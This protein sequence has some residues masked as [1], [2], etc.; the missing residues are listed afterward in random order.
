MV[1][2]ASISRA[3]TS[4][5]GYMN[6]ANVSKLRVATW[7]WAA[8]IA[9]ALVG[10]SHVTRADD[11]M[12][13][14]GPLRITIECQD[15]G[16]TKACPAFLR[17][18][19]DETGL[20]LASP[21]AEAQVVLYVTQAEIA[22]TDRLHLRFV[23]D[24]PGAPPVIELDVDLDTRA[25]D[26][27]Q[28]GQLKPG[29]LRGIALY[30]AATHPDAVTVELAAAADDDAAAVA[31]T[32]WGASASVNG[33]GNWS[34]PYQSGNVFT[35]LSLSRTEA[36]S[37][38]RVGIGGNGGLSRRPPVRGV[39]FNTTQWGLYGN[40]AYER[41]LNGCYAYQVSGSVSR[42][43]PHGQFRYATGAGAAIEWDR[44]KSDDPRGNVLAV[45][46]NASYN[47]EGYNFPNVLKQR[48]AHYP[49]HGLGA[50]A[51]IRKDKVSYNLE[52][53]VSA[54][55]LHPGRRYTLSASPSIDVQVGD[56]IDFSGSL[57]VT[58]R[59]LPE[60][61]IPDDDPQASGRAEY[62]EPTSMFGSVSIRVHWDATNG[63]R[64]NR[65]GFL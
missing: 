10:R 47:V 33:F 28:R 32:P 8:L 21:R 20:M 17:G 65:F 7:W 3:G 39:S 45:A 63:V 27:A 30:V 4:L 9:V 38:F 57:S 1:S 22:N 15:S 61:I 41:H 24:V 50:I 14:A 31:T 62:A 56:H 36:G 60:F 34:G 55:M 40:A 35:N 6:V 26:D 48:F 29:F 54:E 42:D 5:A 13:S 58:R 46:Y 11:R 16:R 64:N 59:Q 37:R 53:N 2:P 23:G 25:D 49:G 19:V 44:Y 18:F 43:D 51:S 12:A 52:L